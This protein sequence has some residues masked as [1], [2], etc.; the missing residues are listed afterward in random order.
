[1]ISSDGLLIRKSGQAKHLPFVKGVGFN[2]D[3]GD[4]IANGPAQAA[5]DYLEILKNFPAKKRELLDVH[6][7]SVGHPDYLDW[8]LRNGYQLLMPRQGDFVDMLEKA[9]RLIQENETRNLGIHI[10]DLRPD[11]PQVIGAPE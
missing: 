8:R 2:L 7:I 5:L 11:A 10:L 3:T 1:L 6:E 9:S 4:S